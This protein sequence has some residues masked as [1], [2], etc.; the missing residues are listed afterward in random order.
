MV[1]LVSFSSFAALA[2]YETTKTANFTISSS[3]IAHVDQSTTAGGISI[4]IA[5]VPSATGSVTTATYTG[6]P[7]PN[8]SWP[9]NITLTHFVAITFNI[10]CKLFSKCKHN[11]I[12]Q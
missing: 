11:D 4:D 5:G 7:Q 9:V 1:I 12:L 2:Q 6:N 10:G 3:G 8:A